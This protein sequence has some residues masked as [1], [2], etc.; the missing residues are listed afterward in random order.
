M[1]YKSFSKTCFNIFNYVFLTV[2]SLTCLL[3]F[4]HLL[5]QSFSS[6]A[7]VAS[8]KVTFW[9]IDFTTASYEYALEGGRFFRAFGVSVIRVL[10]G[11]S[12]NVIVMLL[13]AYPLS[14]S[15]EKVVGRNI[16]MA[17]FAVTMFI[18]GGMIPTYI[19]VA[20]MKLLNSIWSLIL[21]GLLNV[22]NMI[23]LMNFIRGLPDELEEAA[24]IDGATVMQTIC[25]VLLPILKPGLATVGLFSIVS[26]WN[27]WFDGM[28]YMNDNTKVPLQTYLRTLVVDF[29]A[30][31]LQSNMDYTELLSKLNA[32]NGRAAQ[33]F[34]AMVPVLAIYPFL[35]KYF[36]KGLVVGSVKG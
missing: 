25:R 26:H 6:A 18:S 24:F 21:P 34:L 4:I 30:L 10:L 3:P 32:Q 35:Q 17:F 13:T 8:G 33:L 1:V 16:Y 29:E 12:L 19:V 11:A 7:A 36:T 9:P 14:K 31:M 28:I 22:H 23:I 5:A 15:K 2:A 27:A 20:R